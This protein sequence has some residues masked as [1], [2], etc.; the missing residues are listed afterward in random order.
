MVRA[1]NELM[2]SGFEVSVD[3]MRQENQTFSVV[4]PLCHNFT[5]RPSYVFKQNDT[6]ENRCSVVDAQ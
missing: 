6:A 3:R 5:S 4:F 2:R 1:S